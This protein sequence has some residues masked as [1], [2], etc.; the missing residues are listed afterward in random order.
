MIPIDAI[1]KIKLQRRALRPMDPSP[2][3]PARCGAARCDVDHRSQTKKAARKPP[4][5]HLDVALNPPA[6]ATAGAAVGHGNNRFSPIQS[7]TYSRKPRMPARRG[8]GLRR[9]FD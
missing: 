1:I 6:A 2:E 5:A 8:C 9:L 3:C 4:L 7:S